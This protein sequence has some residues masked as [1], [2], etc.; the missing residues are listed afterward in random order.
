MSSSRRDL[1]YRM[2]ADPQGFRKGM[3]AAG[4]S[5]RGFYRELRKLEQQQQVV[6]DMMAMGGQAMLGFGVAAG[7]GLALA[8]KAAIDWESAWTGVA[9]VVDGSPE[10]LAALEDELRGLATTLPQTHAEIAGVAAAAGQLGVATQDVAQFTETMVN[11]GVA[12][13]LSS[14]EAAF[15]LSRLMNIMQTAPEEVENLGSAIVGLG[16]NSATTEAEIVEMALRIAGAGQTIGLTES[17]VLGFSAALSSVGVE[18]EAG[19]T[20]ISTAFKLI[21]NAVRDGG[22]ELETFAQ[23]AGITAN[24]FATRFREAPAEAITLFVE[25]LGRM[26]ERGEN[27]NAVLNELG[28]GGIRLSDSMLRL[29]GA[30]D[31]LNETLQIGNDE[32]D[33]NTALIEEA[34]RRYQTTEAQ[35]QIARNQLTELGIVLGEHL[36]PAINQFLDTASGMLTFF[37]ELHGT[38]H[39]A[40]VFLGAAATAVGLLGGASLVAAPRVAELGQNLGEMGRQR[41][42]RFLTGMANIM[43]GPWGAAMGLGITLVGALIA[44]HAQHVE[45]VKELTDTL[46]DQT[47]A[48]TSNTRVWALNEL[49]KNGAAEAAQALGIDMETLVDAALGEAAALEAVNAALD[50]QDSELNQALRGAQGYSD[51]ADRQAER[52]EHVRDAISG[53]NGELE[54]ADERWQ[55]EQEAMEGSNDAKD[56]A[57]SATEEASAAEQ[58]LAENLGFATEAAQVASDAISDLDEKVK[59]LIDSA[60]ELNGATRD[61]EAGFDELTDKVEE[62]GATLDRTT[63]AGRENEAA[64]EALVEDIA[65]LAIATAKET[66]SAEDANEVLSQQR[67]R[68]EDVLKQAGFTEEQIEEYI[69]VLDQIPSEIETLVE[70]HISITSTERVNRIITEQFGNRASQINEDGGVYYPAA[71]GALREAGVFSP[72]FPA[73]Y[74]FAEMQTGGEAFIPRIGDRSRSL[75]I[76]QEAAAWHRAS[77]VPHEAGGRTINVYLTSYGPEFSTQQVMDDLALRGLV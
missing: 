10:Q 4:E 44:Q 35:I 52:A 69:G 17:D 63:E 37:Q 15:A 72:V 30:G 14:E 19:G 20:A 29:A 76:L 71:E 5:S 62:N 21:D 65:A 67:D 54:D 13:N 66:G 12:T 48:I 55:R 39:Q 33:S 53:L 60:F 36:L 24:E 18:A 26:N 74:A 46:D 28:M 77:V 61:V 34:E 16:N 58:V 1:I 3:E 27:V 25:G 73:R 22:E 57:T 70:A 68:L 64:V 56:E 8:A 51:E 42:G 40:L 49:E 50:A 9:K 43:S 32:W 6:D 75:G 31:L 7:A 47:G 41:T 38:D 11:L 45:R 59:A 2:T 23:V